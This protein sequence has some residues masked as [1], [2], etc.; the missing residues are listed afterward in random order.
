ML[1]RNFFSPQT[2]SYHI[3]AVALFSCSAQNLKYFHNQMKLM[4]KK[5]E[6]N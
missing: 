5:Y 2:T 3:A 6:K 1:I 4:I